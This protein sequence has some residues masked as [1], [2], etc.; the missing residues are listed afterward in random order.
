MTHTTTYRQK[1]NGWQ[2]IV[3]WKDTSGQW[4]QKSKQGFD[5]KADAKEYEAQL[6]QAIKNRPRPVDQALAG[7]SLEK[8]CEVYLKNK[9]SISAGTGLQY[10][11]AVRSLKDVAKKP[12]RRITF[13]DLQSAVSAWTIGP[14]TQKNYKSKLNILF[15][16]AIKP[17]CLISH[18]PVPDIEIA[19]RRDKEERLAISEK[20]FKTLLRICKTPDVHLA[21]AVAYY[22][23]LRRGELLALTWN[24][25]DWDRMT[26]TVNKQVDGRYP[27]RPAA[28]PKTRNSFRTIPVPLVLICLLRTYHDTRPM[29]IDRR[30]IAQ[31]HRTM[32]GLVHAL[33]KIDAR[34]SPHSLRHTY[35]TNLLANGVDVRTVAALLGDTV[36]TVIKTYIH[37]TD[38]MREA[39][40]QDIQKIFSTNF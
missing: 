36:R 10:T 9:K 37:Y 3:S 23:G 16:A 32:Y 15:R 39:A 27:Y 22:T 18:N 34:L 38:D 35:A 1:D 21:A 26:V 6:L 31:P 7:I 30:I 17:Y 4:H 40:A 29:S 24:D 14:D 19:R 8:F 2:I 25:I 11:Q 12:L 20:Q 28:E 13:M 33:K 5:R